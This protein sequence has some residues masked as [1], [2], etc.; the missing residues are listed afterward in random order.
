[1]TEETRYCKLMGPEVLGQWMVERWF[2]WQMRLLDARRLA[3]FCSDRGTQVS[4]SSGWQI[5]RLWQLGLLRAD[6]VQSNK[7]LDGEGLIEVGSDGRDQIFYADARQIPSRSDG[8]VGVAAKL[9]DLDSEV[10]PFFHPFRFYVVQYLLH[11]VGPFSIRPNISPISTFTTAGMDSY[12]DLVGHLLEDFNKYSSSPAFL[13]YV[14]RLNDFASLAI[15]T[16]PC[17]F[18]RMFGTQRLRALYPDELGIDLE[19]FKELSEDERFEK[20]WEVHERRVA[21]QSAE[22]SGYYRRAGLDRLR[23]VHQT[24]CIDTERLNSDKDVLTLLRL[25]KGRRPLKIRN[26]VGAA[27]LV[28]IMAETVRRFLEAARIGHGRRGGRPSQR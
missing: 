20:G 12:K 5:E 10:K 6:Y 23:E 4:W 14:E 21:E 28:R 1:M 18:G 11:P 9:E 19:E 17:V 26:R 13:E 8:W 3:K 2:I 27:L 22:L 7:D 15:A 16:E 25:T 24:L